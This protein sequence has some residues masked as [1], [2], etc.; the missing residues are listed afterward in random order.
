MG[1]RRGAPRRTYRLSPSA[2]AGGRT[3][4]SMARAARARAGRTVS[5]TAAAEAIRIPAQTN[6]YRYVDGSALLTRRPAH[7]EPIGWAMDQTNEP[8]PMNSP[9]RR[10]GMRSARSGMLSAVGQALPRPTR[11]MAGMAAVTE[12]TWDP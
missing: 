12:G 11:I 9:M 6:A 4:S 1:D 2:G 5:M 8:R 10:T 7:P 3:A